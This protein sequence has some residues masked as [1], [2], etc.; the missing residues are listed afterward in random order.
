MMRLSLLTRVSIGKFVNYDTTKAVKL[1]NV[2]GL[3]QMSSF[4]LLA[5]AR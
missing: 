5:M 4:S 1:S 2:S 3:M